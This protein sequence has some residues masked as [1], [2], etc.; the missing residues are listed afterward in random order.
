MTMRLLTE[1]DFS[2]TVASPVF[3]ERFTV[4]GFRSG[5]VTTL[6]RGLVR[7]WNGDVPEAGELEIGRCSGVGIGSTVKVDSGRQS[8]RIG[9]FVSGGTNLRFV[10]NGQHETNTMCM[11]M[12][13]FAGMG[14]ADPVTPQLGDTVLKNDLWIGDEAMILGG[15]VVENG[16][17]I[18]ARALLPPGFRSEPY[19]IYVGTPARLHRFRFGE[20]VRRALL[21]LAWWELP[22]AWVKEHNEAFLTNLDEDEGRSL[23]LLA[24]LR[25]RRGAAQPFVPTPA[26]VSWPGGEA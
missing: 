12:L 7:T 18:G 4:L 2:G 15:G 25:R 22:L 8:L 3:G 17:I 10:L 21:E 19:G 20:R 16:C 24:E 14:I 6:P 11:Y 23:E 13:K 1:A 26:A 5:G 9:R